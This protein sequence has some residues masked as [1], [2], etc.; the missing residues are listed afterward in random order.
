[1]RAIQRAKFTKG[2]QDAVI[3]RSNVALLTLMMQV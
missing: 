3:L 1:L 2:F